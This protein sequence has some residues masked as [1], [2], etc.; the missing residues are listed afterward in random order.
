ME[1]MWRVQRRIL[2]CSPFAKTISWSQ[3]LYFPP[4][5][6]VLFIWKSGSD[7][8]VNAWHMRKEIWELSI[9]LLRVLSVRQDETSFC[10]QWREFCEK[11]RKVSSYKS[12]SQERRFWK[13]AALVC[14]QCEILQINTWWYWYT[15]LC[16][17]LLLVD[18][19]FFNLWYCWLSFL[20]SVGSH[21]CCWSE[22]LNL[23]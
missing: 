6:V 10:V 19:C 4:S 23:P 20:V 21:N 9:L 17:N 1:N 7:I 22:L 14:R 2:L 13:I 5:C 18:C 3:E 12:M 16:L 11:F 15:G 8:G